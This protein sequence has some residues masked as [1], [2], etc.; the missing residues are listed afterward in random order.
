MAPRKRAGDSSTGRSSTDPGE[1]SGDRL[2]RVTAPPELDDKENRRR[3]GL[4]ETPDTRGPYMVEL[5]V[6]HSSG[7]AGAAQA[8]LRL[9]QQVFGDTDARR[10]RGGPPAP[11]KISKTYF[12]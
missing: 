8:F 7:L 10:A 6:Q 5:N 11:V 9:F 4:G 2:S 3:W 1:F 12:R